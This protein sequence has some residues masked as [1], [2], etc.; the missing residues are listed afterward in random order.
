MLLGKENANTNLKVNRFPRINCAH[1]K[2]SI[3]DCWGHHTKEL[4]SSNELCKNWAVDSGR[5]KDRQINTDMKC[6]L[7][8][9][10][11][12]IRETMLIHLL[13]PKN[14][15]WHWLYVFYCQIKSQTKLHI[16]VCGSENHVQINWLKPTVCTR[17]SGRWH[18]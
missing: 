10:H 3:Q 4:W 5:T 6:F 12:K 9:I 11:D 2:W 14:I 16:S 13:Y 8:N 15:I 1:I 7:I 18:A 17:E